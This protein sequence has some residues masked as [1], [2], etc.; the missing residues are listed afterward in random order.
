MMALQNQL[1]QMSFREQN[2][3]NKFG[4]LQQLQGKFIS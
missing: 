1:E 2:D 4:Q 3:A